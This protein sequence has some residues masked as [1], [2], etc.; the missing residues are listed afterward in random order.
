MRRLSR[1]RLRSSPSPCGCGDQSCSSFL[2]RC[3][4]RGCCGEIAVAQHDPATHE[5][6]AAQHMSFQSWDLSAVS[7]P[8]EHLLR[9]DSGAGAPPKNGL[10]LHR[11]AFRRGRSRDLSLQEGGV[12]L[13]AQRGQPRARGLSFVALGLRDPNLVPSSRALPVR[14][15]GTECQ[16]ALSSEVSVANVRKRK[17]SAAKG[18]PIYATP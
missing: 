10:R 17:F 18:E 16:S 2:T 3:L 4:A 5:A 14:F 6:L 9:N 11:R 8:Q 7:V 13:G 15:H 12:P 1:L